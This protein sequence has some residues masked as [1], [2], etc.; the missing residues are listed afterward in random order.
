M[1]RLAIVL[2]RRV[3]V[4]RWKHA[5][6]WLTFTEDTVE[7]FELLQ[8]VTL[9]ETPSVVTLLEKRELDPGGQMLLGSRR[10]WELVDFQTSERQLVWILGPGD[11]P[12]AAHELWEDDRMELLVTYSCTSLVLV[13]DAGEWASSREIQWNC[14]P[15]SIV[16]A[17]PYLLAMSA[18]TVEIRSPVTGTLLHTL[19]L[20]RLTLISSK[21]DIFFTT[22]KQGYTTRK[23]SE[24]EPMSKFCEPASHMYKIPWNTLVGTAGTEGRPTTPHA[25]NSFNS[26]TENSV[27]PYSRT[28]SQIS[29]LSQPAF[30]PAS[31]VDI[32]ASLE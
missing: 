4:Y 15:Q 20:P 28:N 9:S 14:Q 23:N 24:M 1:L 29:G 12:T 11:V 21:D 8:E 27:E 31:S 25:L 7:G 32:P 30:S 6:E 26:S 16:P 18:D 22:T 19:N 5:E 13:E 2:G 3:L 10:G 17:F